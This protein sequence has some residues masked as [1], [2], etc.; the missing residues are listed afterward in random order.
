MIDRHF[1]KRNK[2]SLSSIYGKHFAVA[3]SMDRT[4][5]SP[6]SILGI[7][8]LKITFPLVFSVDSYGLYLTT[9]IVHEGKD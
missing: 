3:I 9:V 4:A 6:E 5:L 2:V 7:M 1:S 8:T